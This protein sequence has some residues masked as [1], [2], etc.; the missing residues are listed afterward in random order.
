MRAKATSILFLGK[1]IQAAT[2]IHSI[3]ICT[4]P[5]GAVYSMVSNLS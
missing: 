3:A 5:E 1:S 2:P 4:A